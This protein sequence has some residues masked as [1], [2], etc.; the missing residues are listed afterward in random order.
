MICKWFFKKVFIFIWFLFYGVWGKMNFKFR[1]DI[2]LVI[3]LF[4]DGMGWYFIILWY[5]VMCL[6]LFFC[7][8]NE[9]LFGIWFFF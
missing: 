7:I 9:I 2:L 5:V 3:G 4:F 1:N 6:I 8:V